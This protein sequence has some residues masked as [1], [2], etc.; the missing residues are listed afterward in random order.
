[1]TGCVNPGMVNDGQPPKYSANVS[2]VA[3]TA[4]QHIDTH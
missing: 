3:V 2:D 1:V 4:C